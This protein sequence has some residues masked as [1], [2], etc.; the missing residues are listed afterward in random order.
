MRDD[1]T[2][3]AMTDALARLAASFGK[4]YGVAVERQADE[5]TNG[6]RRVG[7]PGMALTAAVDEVVLTL[8]KFPSLAE[9]IAVART[10]VPR[11]DWER[12]E[13]DDRCPQCKGGYA[14]RPTDTLGNEEW[15]CGCQYPFR[16]GY[17]RQEWLEERRGEPFVDRELARRTDPKAKRFD[18]LGASRPVTLKPAPPLPNDPLGQKIQAKR[19]NLK[20]TGMTSI[21]DI[22]E[23]TTP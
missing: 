16:L 9:L 4:P 5:W 11:T 22:L 17:A 8:K 21:L 18:R 6:F 14:W 1:V 23:E 19:D 3:L 13:Q 15:L 2:R 10:H 20:A 7:I 12:Q